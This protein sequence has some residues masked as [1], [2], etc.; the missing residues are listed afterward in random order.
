MF[1][2]IHTIFALLLTQIFPELWLLFFLAFLSHWVLDF[3]PHYGLK[4][5]NRKKF[6]KMA[7]IDGIVSLIFLSIYLLN[8]TIP[9][10]VL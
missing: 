8:K 3:F 9:P 1:H 2:T 10:I 6:I 7:V 5:F 4:I